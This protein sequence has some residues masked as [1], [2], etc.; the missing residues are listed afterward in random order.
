MSSA[1]KS[2]GL[3]SSKD[4][5][6]R[7]VTLLFL[8]LSGS[9]AFS[10][11][12]VTSWPASRNALYGSS[13]SESSKS[14]ARTHAILMAHLLPFT[15][16]AVRPNCLSVAASIF[17]PAGG[18]RFV[19]TAA[20]LSPWSDQSLHGSPVAMLLAREVERFPAE[21]AMFVTRLT[22]ELL[23]PFGRVPV[24]VRSRIVRPGRKVQIV[25]ASLWNGEQEVGRATALRMRMSDVS[26]PE[27]PEDHPHDSP[28]SLQIW[29]GGW[30]PGAEAYHL[31][32]VEKCSSFF[33][34]SRRRHT[35]WTGDWSS[36]VCSSD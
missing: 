3:T 13:N 11:M 30:R 8:P 17:E 27:E 16:R 31:I 25:E 26:V 6:V 23:R 22:V 35:R 4:F 20:A 36:D 33:F 32:G 9:F 29:A 1:S 2:L 34:S 18:G 21:Q 10:P 5:S 12:T 24:E 19:A 28:E 7:T 15:I 14:A